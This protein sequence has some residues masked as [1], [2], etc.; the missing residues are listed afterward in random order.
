MPSTSRVIGP[1]EPAHAGQQHYTRGFLK[2]YDP[3]V[4]GL[5]TRI[6]RCPTA[7]VRAHYQQHIRR[8]HLDIGPG[9][10]YFLDHVQLPDRL[11]VTLLDPNL[12]V[13]AHATRRLSALAPT[14]VEA[15]ILAPLPT[16][17]P[18][19]SVALNFVLHCLP[20]EMQDKAPAIHN[21][22]SVLDAD[23]V[24]FGATILGEPEL[25]TVVS[26]PA[27]RANN[28]RGIFDNLGGTAA[29]LRATLAAS[30]REVDVDVVGSAA[31]FAAHRPR[32]ASTR[33]E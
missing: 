8:R 12:H 25:H 2:I 6:W 14:T 13:L 10:G 22:A 4:L 5:F 17:G 18:F 11:E 16:L 33:D 23:G 19:G 30:F 3:L 21:A 9:T 27:L 15:D 31:I 1:D 26:R 20:G 32:P 28:R 24:L 29:D 7:R